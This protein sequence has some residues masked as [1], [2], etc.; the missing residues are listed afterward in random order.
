MH[1]SRRIFAAVLTGL[2][3][4]AA[5]CGDDDDDPQG[6]TNN[7]DSIIQEEPTPDQAPGQTAPGPGN[8]TA[9]STT[10]TDGE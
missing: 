2:A 8:S 5:G 1:R 4:V 9:P 3:L 7:E 6:R 10:R